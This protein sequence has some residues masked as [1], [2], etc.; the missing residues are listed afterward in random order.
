MRRL[1]ACAASCLV[2]AAC[3]E[4]SGSGEA[5]PS[6]TPRP[7]RTFTV[8]GYVTAEGSFGV[9][10][11]GVGPSADLHAG[12]RV[13]VRSRAGASLATG[14]L[15]DGFADDDQPQRRCIYPFSVRKVPDGR[16]PYSVQVAR[17]EPVP[18]DRRQ[19]GQVDVRLKA[20]E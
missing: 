3:G 18:F 1:V 5:T 2:L 13:V 19:A 8:S 7:V 14:A 10:C 11:K 17:R 4:P 20:Q 16:G 6:A 12:T 9:A 15:G